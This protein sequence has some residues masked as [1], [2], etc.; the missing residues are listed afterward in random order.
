[1]NMAHIKNLS[2]ILVFLDYLRENSLKF[3]LKQDRPDS[4]MVT[5][6]QLFFRVEVDF[7]SDHIEYSYFVGDESVKTDLDVLDL[8]IKEEPAKLKALGILPAS[9]QLFGSG[10]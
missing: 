6:S 8:I 4:I 2:D 9:I 5:F 7:F 10:D 1:M 3:D